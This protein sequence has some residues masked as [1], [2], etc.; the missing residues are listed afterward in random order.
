MVISHKTY[1]LNSVDCQKMFDYGSLLMY[2]RYIVH[3]SLNYF[4][5]VGGLARKK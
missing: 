4:S 2:I 1:C 3:M 5:F